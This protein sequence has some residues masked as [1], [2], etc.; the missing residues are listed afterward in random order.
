[1]VSGTSGIIPLLFL[2]TA[3]ENL[4]RYVLPRQFDFICRID[5]RRMS[6]QT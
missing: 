6:S 3:V 5:F 1:M 2:I 4:L